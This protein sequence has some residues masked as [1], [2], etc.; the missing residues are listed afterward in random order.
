VNFGR[1]CLWA[2]LAF[3]AGCA[4]GFAAW[5]E[6]RAPVLALLLPAAIAICSSRSQAFLVGTGYVVGLMRH[7]AAFIGTWFDNSLVVGSAAVLT[8][9]V[10]TGAVWAVG[11]TASPRASRRAAAMGLAWLIAVLPPATLAIP[12]HPLVASGYVLPGWGWFGVVA[13]LGA[14]MLMSV[15][16]PTLANRRRIAV[17]AAMCASSAMGGVLLGRMPESLPAGNGIVAMSTAWGHLG[18]AEDAL[19]RIERIARTPISGRAVTVVWPESILGRY[20]PSLYPVLDLELLRNARR[21][22]KV[23]VIGMDVPLRGNRLLNS[24]VAFYPDGSTATAVARQPAPMS[25]WKPWRA[26]NTFIADWSAHNVMNLGQGDRAAVIFC[27]EEYL[28]SLYL[29][30]EALDR[31]T[32]YVAMRNTWAAPYPASST[33]QT[34]HSLG[35]ARL[36]G[37]PYLVADNRPRPALAP[38]DWTPSIAP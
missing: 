17:V 38:A 36:F 13:S 1:R 4:L 8:Y 22:G 34:W 33:I 7:T 15:V 21:E 16:L 30:N 11:W 18:G 27:Y 32:V 23:H 26:E 2:P 12:G 31:P 19:A 6:G 3:I 24:A 5:G 9:A 28:P 20:E 10:I 35:M 29:L 25:L 14:A 37:R